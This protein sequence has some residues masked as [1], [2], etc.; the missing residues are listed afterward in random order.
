MSEPL[1]L[2]VARRVI[3]PEIGCHLAGYAANVIAES[4]HDD[5]TAMAFYFR[6]GKTEAIMVSVTL[7]SMMTDLFNRLRTEIEQ[8][9]SVPCEH[10]IVHT[11]HTHSGPSTVIGDERVAYIETVL[12]PAVIAAAREAKDNAA[13]VKMRVSVGES[14]VG[15]NRREL[16]RDNL[17][18]LGQ[19]PWGPF[20]PKMTV[21]SFCNEQG[22]D[23][24]NL[25]HYGCHGTASGKNRE[26]SRDWMGVMID[27][28]EENSGAMTAFFNGP[29]GDVGPRLANGKTIG[30]DN[31]S[32]AVEHGGLAG[33]DAVRIYKQRGAYSE[34]DLE[35]SSQTIAIPLKP[36]VPKEVAEQEAAKRVDATTVHEKQLRRYYQEIVATYEGDY[37]ELDAFEFTQTVIRLGNVA[38]VAFPFELFSEIGMRIAQLSPF[39]H[40]L[41]VSISN[42]YNSYFATEDQLCRGGYEI[43]LFLTKLHQQYV[44]NA[45]FHMIKQTVAHLNKMKGE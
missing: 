32:Y 30:F 22:K 41:S 2:G 5:L 27:M 42:G 34:A 20:D 3:N 12:V 10:C 18:M 31:V 40:T 37:T 39:P 25:I 1:F 9:T 24:A 36:R 19:N 6:Q 7:C 33:H 21:L 11:T 45:D 8:A 17:V 35:V 16:N 13:P 38:F 23:V 44:N 4:L 28:L 15:V 43:R 14:R 29:E 26:I